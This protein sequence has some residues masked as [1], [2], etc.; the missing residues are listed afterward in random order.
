MA[1]ETFDR[2]DEAIAPEIGGPIL[3]RELRLFLPSIRLA[4]G[5]H[6]FSKAHWTAMARPAPPPAPRRSTRRSHQV[7][8]EFLADGAQEAGAVG[9]KPDQLRPFHDDGIHRAGLPGA[10]L[11][12]STVASAPALWGMVAF[13]PIPPA[14]GEAHQAAGSSSGGTWILIYWASI[15]LARRA[16]L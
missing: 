15:T 5:A 9:I 10:D 14:S 6:Q 11:A 8:G 4:P 2:A 12:S 13:V 3:W 1:G 7:D 16:A